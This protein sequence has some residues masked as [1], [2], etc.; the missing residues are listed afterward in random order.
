MRKNYISEKKLQSIV[1][2]VLLEE[3]SWEDILKLGSDIAKKSANDAEKNGS[4]PTNDNK[5]SEPPKSSTSST[6]SV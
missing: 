4:K 1:R 2:K 6:L 3:M 5:K